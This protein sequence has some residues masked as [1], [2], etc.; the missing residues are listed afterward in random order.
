MHIGFCNR[1]RIQNAP[2]TQVS[3]DGS[4]LSRRFRQ[5]GHLHRQKFTYLFRMAREALLLA[6]PVAILFGLALVVLLLALGERDL[7]F[8]EVALP[9]ERGADRGVAFLLHTLEQPG[10]LALVQHELAAMAM[11]LTASRLMVYRAAATKDAGA[12]RVSVE[13]AMAKAFATEAAQ[14]IVDSAVQLSGGRGVLKESKVDQLYRAI[15]PLRIYEGTTDI[16]HVVIARAIL[17]SRRQG[18]A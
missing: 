9:V 3:F 14:R 7:A 6:G 4:S 1:R 8:H 2:K 13:S 15:R 12:P 17:K 18:L 16:Q 5:I 11:D 10:E